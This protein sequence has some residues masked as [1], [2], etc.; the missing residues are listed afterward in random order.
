MASNMAN[1]DVSSETT[2]KD[3]ND[4]FASIPQAQDRHTW[5]H[6]EKHPDL[7]KKKHMDKHFQDMTQEDLPPMVEG[8][9]KYDKS[10]LEQSLKKQNQEEWIKELGLTDEQR[11]QAEAL[12]QK[13]REEME[14]I[15][16]KM[17]ELKE[18]AEKL[19]EANKAEFE[20][21]L[22]PEQKEKLQQMQKAR[23]KEQRHMKPNRPNKIEKNRKK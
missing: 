7:K 12:R 14:P 3:V 15:M 2:L 10:H 16:Q 22:T 23:H 4:T 13:N 8:E 18:Q 19:R 20:S 1:A 9:E 6:G 21:I 5:R 11:K 17:K